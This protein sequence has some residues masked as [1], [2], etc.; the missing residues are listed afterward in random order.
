MICN[1]LKFTSNQ[2]MTPTLKCKTNCNKLTISSAIITLCRTQT[3]RIVL[4][5]MPSTFTELFQNTTTTNITCITNNSS[6]QSLIIQPQSRC[7]TQAR[8][9]CIKG[10]LLINTP[11]KWLTFSCELGQ[12][13]SNLTKSKN[14]L[15]II[16]TQA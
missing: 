12:R 5:W 9:Q 3:F 1:D 15:A 6:L 16:V 8:F 14:K 2:M 11:N 4:N 10:F 7:R 13:S